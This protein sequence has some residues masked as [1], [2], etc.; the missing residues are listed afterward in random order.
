MKLYSKFHISKHLFHALL[1][2]IFLSEVLVLLSFQ[3][4]FRMPIGR[5]E[6]VGLEPNV[7][8]GRMGLSKI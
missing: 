4:C 8:M 2:R 5:F 1:V 3:L 7:E 6:K